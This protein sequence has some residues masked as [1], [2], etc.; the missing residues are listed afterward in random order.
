MHHEQRTKNMKK[1]TRRL[2]PVVL[3]ETTIKSLEKYVQKNKPEIKNRSHAIEIAITK[4][5]KEK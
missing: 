5:L 2:I 4:L 1:E 3:P